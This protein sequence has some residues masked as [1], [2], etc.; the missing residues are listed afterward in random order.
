MSALQGSE[1]SPWMERYRG[2]HVAVLGATGFIG[3]WVA[4]L[5]SELGAELELIVRS[6]SKAEPLLATLGVEGRIREL[7][8]QEEVGALGELLRDSEPAITFNAVGYGVHPSERDERAAAHLNARLVGA[9]C[10]AVSLSASDWGGPRLVHV[11]SALEYGRAG[12][13]L[14]EGTKADPTTLYGR[15]KLAGTRLVERIGQ[16]TGTRALTARLFTVYGPG[17]HEGRLLPSLFRTADSGEPLALTEGGQARD[18]TY[19]EDVAEGLL[20]LGV[21]AAEPGET[22]NLATGTLTEVRA[23]V[24]TAAQVLSIPEERLLFGAVP[25]RPDEMIHEDVRVERLERLTSWRPRTSIAEGVAR[26]ARLEE[27][28]GRWPS[29]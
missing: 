26:T 29:D 20:R 16:E 7:H 22:V 5:L 21:S 17:E 6:G 9:L 3:R 19:V 27:R 4:R 15:T 25:T 28:V 23:F 2:L 11:G 10:D 13:D 1:S 12:G 8:L 24:E 18:F 14:H